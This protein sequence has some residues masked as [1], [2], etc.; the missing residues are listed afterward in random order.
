MPR[1]NRHCLLGHVWHLTHRCHHKA[2][3]LRF[4]RDRRR[5]LRWVFEATKRFGL[6]VLDYYGYVP[7]P[8]RP[9]N[10]KPARAWQGCGEA[11]SICLDIQAWPRFQ[12][13]KTVPVDVQQ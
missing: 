5:Y 9:E 1:A 13:K 12:R 4:S 6:S 2:F 11:C 10:A 7:Q 3:L 8:L